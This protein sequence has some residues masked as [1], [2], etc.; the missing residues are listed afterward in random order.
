MA[1]YV[2]N[3]DLM[4]VCF[5]VPGED[6]KDLSVHLGSREKSRELTEAEFKSREVQKLIKNK[7]LKHI[8]V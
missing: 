1:D 7:V 6:G 8:K 3:R 2:K 4:P 5:C